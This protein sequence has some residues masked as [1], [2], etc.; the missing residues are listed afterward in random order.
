M[1]LPEMIGSTGKVV[2]PLAP[3][4]TVKVKNELWT[5][6]STGEDIDAG[7]NITVVAQDGLRLIV[8]RNNTNSH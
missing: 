8:R 5:A 2:S 1:G 7:E 3:E 6:K 4:G